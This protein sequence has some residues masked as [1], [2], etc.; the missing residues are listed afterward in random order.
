MYALTDV[1]G[2]VLPTQIS[3]SP[4][5]GRRELL[6]DTLTLSVDGTIRRVRLFRLYPGYSLC[7]ASFCPPPI[8]TRDDDAR[9]TWV[10][11]DRVVTLRYGEDV[12]LMRSGAVLS[13][14]ALVVTEPFGDSPGAWR[15]RRQ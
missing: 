2:M 9:G 10:S 4:A 15:Y 6:A 11:R 14:G 1:A 3:S 8:D 13:D 5:S 12:E 7:T